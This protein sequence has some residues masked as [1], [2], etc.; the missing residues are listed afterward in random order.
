MSNKLIVPL[1]VAAFV[2]TAVA[3]VLNLNLIF[4]FGNI[5]TGAATS[6]GT[7][8]SNLTI[9]GVTAITNNVAAIQFGS[10]YVNASCTACI[11][12]SDGRMV[13]GTCCA[14]F[15]NVTS[16]FLL[17]NTGN[18]N[19]SV[20]YT[21]AGNCTAA[22][23][24]G[25]TSPVFKIKTTNNL[26]AQQSGEYGALDTI[27]SCNDSTILNWNITTYAPVLA[28]GDWLCGNSTN[29]PLVF[30]NTQDA[31]VIDI[32]VTIPQDAPGGSGV[33]SATFT[34]N[35]LSSG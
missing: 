7:G 11:M 25:G 30:D 17:E 35:A 26:A 28:A 15:T 2:F 23:L 10:G 21:C 12:D 29:Y 34:F 20:N 14:S 22:L 5:L 27:Q 3:T 6:T 32:N 19:L 31:V 4:D 18:L 16:G 8:V 1:F 13:N 33:Q 9:T 24:I